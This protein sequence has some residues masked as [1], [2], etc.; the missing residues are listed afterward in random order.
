MKRMRKGRLLS[1]IILFMF[2]M[3]VAAAC[4]QP[5]Q[6]GAAL[7]D[8]KVELV[9][10]KEPIATGEMKAYTVKLTRNGAPVDVDKVYYYMNMKGMHHPAEGT[11]KRVEKGVYRIEL[12]LAMPG[13]WQAEITLYQ[14][15]E[16]RKVE[17]F[18]IQAEGKKYMQYMKGYNADTA[19]K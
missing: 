15:S 12:P 16:T 7:N 2:L 5:A 11:M 3:M 6:S 9:K 14:G 13:E 4:G 8:V 10:E 18:T 1:S 17:G 19:G